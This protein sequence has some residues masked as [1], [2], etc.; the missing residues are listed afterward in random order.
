MGL[1]ERDLFSDTSPKKRREVAVY[2]YRDASGM[3]LYEVVRYEPKDFR[4]RRCDDQNKYVWN[5][6]GV[7][8]VV[9]RL[10]DIQGKTAVV[11]VEGEKDAN[12]LWNLGIPATSNVS[13]AGKWRDEYAQQL[14][15]ADVQRVRIIPDND[16]PGLQH[17]HQV[18]QSCLA[19]GLDARLV[20]LPGLADKGDVS[21]FLKTHSKNELT[22]LLKAAPAY[23]APPSARHKSEVP[24]SVQ[25][26]D[27]QTHPRTAPRDLDSE[28]A[29]LAAVLTDDTVLPIVAATLESSDFYHQ[30]HRVVFQRMLAMQREGVGVDSITLRAALDAARGEIKAVG[31]A[32]FLDTLPVQ[33]V[34]RSNVQQYAQTVKNHSLM[35][36]IH[37]IGNKLAERAYDTG[38]E[39]LSLI[40]S[41]HSSISA[42][43]QRAAT[44][45]TCGFVTECAAT[46][47]PQ[48]TE[49][50]WPG[51]IPSGILML[52]SGDGGIGKSVM[53]IDLVARVSRGAAF[54][55][56]AG[57]APHGKVLMLS[58]EDEP[59]RVLVPRLIAAGADRSNVQIVKAQAVGR[60]K[61][62]RVVLDD[63]GIRDLGVSVRHHN[64]VL[65]IIDPVL[66][67]WGKQDINT[68]NEIRQVLG[69]ISDVA[70]QTR[71]LIIGL[72]H[73][74]KNAANKG[75]DR[76]LA[77]VAFGNTARLVYGVVADPEDPDRICFGHLK[78][79]Y[80]KRPP[81][82]SYRLIETPVETEKGQ[83]HVPR[84]E[85]DREP[86]PP[87]T[88]ERYFS[89]PR[90]TGEGDRKIDE[91]IDFLKTK[92]AGGPERQERIE[93]ASREA[94]ISLVTLRRARADAN[95][96]T[97]K[98]GYQGHWYWGL[99]P[100]PRD[101]KPNGPQ[102]MPTTGTF[103]AGDDDDEGDSI[104]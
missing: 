62:R 13:G 1:S 58:A 19:A 26:S 90:S 92:L 87:R 46:I 100:F 56:G 41:Y 52:L 2:Q 93:A 89:A 66:A 23:E 55:D 77:G 71:C 61:T 20:V 97:K 59:E 50:V 35:R 47:K 75:K 72:M 102:P 65:V 94:G 67:F 63:S 10:N 27:I 40:D 30:P 80:T 44:N 8:R 78:G 82:L 14:K 85:W 4:Q 32:G 33:T 73:V 36:A 34:R 37:S 38:A 91:A 16:P 17:A 54:P 25:H 49:Y 5:L 101:W 84:C 24:T 76:M 88:V 3:L 57:M 15:A 104:D 6:T 86:L 96:Q 21:D 60:G 7:T 9:Y 42:I 69:P 98:A 28:R 70:M 48:I 29:V 79:N 103:H 81:D 64:A 43:Q 18:A 11:V 95:V 99:T 12:A 39:P 53:L 51:R 74:G 22:Q 83:A 31:G 45:G 68:D